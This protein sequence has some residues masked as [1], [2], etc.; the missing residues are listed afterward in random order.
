MRFETN[1][2]TNPMSEPAD[3]TPAAPT[4]TTTWTI[5]PALSRVEF[6]ARMRLTFL[7]NV[8]VVGRSTEIHG[9]LTGA[10]SD[11]HT[12]RRYT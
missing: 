9:A 4:N 6:C 12:T 1:G 10:E 7:A 11:P 8:T 3:T 2:D 5:D